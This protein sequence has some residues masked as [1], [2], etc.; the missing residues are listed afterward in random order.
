MN[1]LFGNQEYF[2]GRSTDAYV[3]I[4]KTVRI[5]GDFQLDASTG[6]ARRIRTKVAASGSPEVGTIGLESFTEVDAGG[7]EAGDGIQ[8][9]LSIADISSSGSTSRETL[10]RWKAVRGSTGGGGNLI[11]QAVTSTGGNFDAISMYS[12]G[13]VVIPKLQA[14]TTGTLPY[15]AS[16]LQGYGWHP[17]IYEA[18]TGAA[19]LTTAFASVVTAQLDRAGWWRLESSFDMQMGSAGFQQITGQLATSSG[20]ILLARKAGGQ[21]NSSGDYGGVWGATIPF[22]AATTGLSVALQARI[23]NSSPAASINADIFARWESPLTT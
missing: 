7:L 20:G 8:V 9:P 6:T 21:A 23:D 14:N 1:K 17:G 10:A 22:E 13:T 5:D 4:E 11:L 3:E 19:A 15:N 12:S 2:K 16:Q 18:T